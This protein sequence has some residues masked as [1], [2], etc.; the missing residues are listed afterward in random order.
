MKVG[1]KGSFHS[2]K[3]GLT[4]HDAPGQSALP[5]ELHDGTIDLRDLA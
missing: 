3:P 2:R 5:Y 4:T 1:L